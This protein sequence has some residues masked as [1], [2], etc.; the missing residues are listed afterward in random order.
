MHISMPLL[1][2]R[3][4]WDIWK[5]YSILG[6]SKS[7]VK[8]GLMT[9][10]TAKQISKLPHYGQLIVPKWQVKSELL[11]VGGKFSEDLLYCIANGPDDS[12]YKMRLLSA[13]S[14]IY[15]LSRLIYKS[16]GKYKKLPEK[17]Y[18]TDLFDGYMESEDEIADRLYLVCK[19][20]DTVDSSFVFKCVE[21]LKPLAVRWVSC[22]YEQLYIH[23]FAFLI[24][25][26]IKRNGEV[27]YPEEGLF[28]KNY[29]NFNYS[30]GIGEE[31]NKYSY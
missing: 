9:T 28:P 25:Y 8:G 7:N 21:A 11:D 17:C 3:H 10:Y 26:V 27:P 24:D 14:R 4:I 2:R 5:C 29:E 16:K 23:E 1:P 12:D 13:S 20:T 18:A 15:Y 30:E 31:F 6:K 19:N 22:L